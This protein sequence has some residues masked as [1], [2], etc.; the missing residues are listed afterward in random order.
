MSMKTVKPPK[1]HYTVHYICLWRSAHQLL[2]LISFLSTSS[3]PY[4]KRVYRCTV[5]D[6]LVGLGGGYPLPIPHIID[7]FGVSLFGVFGASNSTPSASRPCKLK[8]W[9]RSWLS[10]F[11]KHWLLSE[12]TSIRVLLKYGYCRRVSSVCRVYGD[13]TYE[14]LC[15]FHEKSIVKGVHSTHLNST[16]LDCSIIYYAVALPM[17]KLHMVVV[18]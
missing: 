1:T 15:D 2:S 7:A 6:S 9:L 3:G 14:R 8:I 17:I 12:M 16:T 10:L 18:R 5:T 4:L 13:K 11:H